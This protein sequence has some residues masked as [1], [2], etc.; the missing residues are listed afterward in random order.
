MAKYAMEDIELLRSKS[1]ISYQEAVALLDYHNGDL[2]QALIDLEKQGKLRSNSFDM[3]G[4]GKNQKKG[5]NILQ[6]LYRTRFKVTKDG[7]PIVNLSVLFS[8][9]TALI[10]PHIAVI[11]LIASL[12]LGYRISIDTNDPAFEKENLERMVR[13]AA[14]NVKQS[15]SGIARDISQA[16]EQAGSAKKAEPQRSAE[17]MKETVMDEADEK[18][19]QTGSFYN[20]SSYSAFVKNPGSTKSSAPILQVPVKVDSADGNVSYQD[21]GNGYNSVTVD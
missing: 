12:V 11:G 6:K 8:L 18:S 9:I 21:E 1:G 5:M 17:P 10:S 20:S 3:D 13:S 7:T 14:E 2:A 16:V 4:K 19:A 15:V